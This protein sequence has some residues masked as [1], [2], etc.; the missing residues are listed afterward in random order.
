[1]RALN[2]GNRSFFVGDIHAVLR[3]MNSESVDVVY[4]D[5]PFNSNR[6]YSVI[7]VRKDFELT[8]KSHFCYFDGVS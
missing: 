8:L 5:P 1:M 7:G 2:W 3:G 4:L 6:N